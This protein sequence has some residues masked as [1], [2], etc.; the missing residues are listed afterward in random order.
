MDSKVY[1]VKLRA[2]TVFLEGGIG[3]VDNND[4]VVEH[5]LSYKPCNNSDAEREIVSLSIMQ[6][7]VD[8]IESIYSAFTD[9]VIGK[10]SNER[11]RITARKQGMYN[12]LYRYKN[13][14]ENITL[15]KDKRKAF[16]QEVLN[17]DDTADCLLRYILAGCVTEIHERYSDKQEKETSDAG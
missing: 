17:D 4:I 8:D 11:L 14:I 1:T 10:V 6:I 5:E 3:E 7:G 2:F 15:D 12:T 16:C 13:L 9:T